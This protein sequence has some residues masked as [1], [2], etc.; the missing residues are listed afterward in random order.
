MGVRIQNPL[1]EEAKQLTSSLG[2]KGGGSSE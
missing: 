2:L 1:R